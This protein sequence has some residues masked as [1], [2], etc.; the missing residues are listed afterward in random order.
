MTYQPERESLPHGSHHA[1]AM[2]H[3][4]AA[5]PHDVAEWQ[6]VPG[7][8]LNELRR[9]LDTRYQRRVAAWVGSA[10][11]LLLAV[12]LTAWQALQPGMAQ[13][14]L[15]CTQCRELMHAYASHTLGREQAAQVQ[16]HLDRCKSCLD[17]YVKVQQ[18]IGE[19]PSPASQL[20]SVAWLDRVPNETWLAK[21]PM[22]LPSPAMAAAR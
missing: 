10:A 6:P 5:M 22:S 7:G 15:N 2:P 1:G 12:G 4:A 18:E 19:S 20:A 14:A 16:A 11:A 8:T 21:L 3:D 17:Q 9:T 13:H